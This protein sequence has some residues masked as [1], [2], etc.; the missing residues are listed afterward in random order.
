MR[1]ARNGI[2]ARD[3]GE[4]D[5]NEHIR[6]SGVEKYL[7]AASWVHGITAHHIMVERKIKRDIYGWSVATIAVIKMAEMPI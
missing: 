6:I 5:S 2:R 4:A 7:S 1:Y 3:S